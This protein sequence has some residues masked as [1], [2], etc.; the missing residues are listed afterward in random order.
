M[1]PPTISII[2]PSFNQGQYLEETIRS[3]IEQEGDFCIDYLI[4]DGGS[5]DNSV[6]IIRKY[7]DLINRKK[8]PLNCRGISLRWISEKDDGQADA[9][10]K[11]IQQT[12]GEILSYIN[13]DDL[14]FPGA[15][16]QVIKQF[17]SHP[18]YDFVYGDGDV[19][20]EKGMLLWEWLSRPY[21]HAIIKSYHSLWN[22]FANY[23]M[24]QAT[25]WRSS[26]HNKIGMFDKSLHYSMDLEF[27]VRGGAAGLSLIHIPVKLGKFRMIAGT[28]SLSTPT[29]FWIDNME[30]FRRYNG[31]SSMAKYFTYFY[32]NHAMNNG[33]DFNQVK[34]PEAKLFDRWRNLSSREICILRKKASIGIS[35]AMILASIHLSGSVSQKQKADHFFLDAIRRHPIQLFHPVAWGL[36]LR[37]VFGDKVGLQWQRIKQRLVNFYRNRRY[38]YRYLQKERPH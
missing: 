30:I 19:I 12:R 28:K 20:D 21:D 1:N 34:N 16:G 37:K 9:I 32:F 15:F 27:W 17:Q 4:M 18:E 11:G 13:S 7:D 36:V 26:V 35:R 22:D 10:N 14:Y 3:V 5:T 8:L 2:T 38:L 6:E 23:I 25:F 24:Q 33:F 29:V 31:A